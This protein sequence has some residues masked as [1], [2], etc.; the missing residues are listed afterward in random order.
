MEQRVA[1]PIAAFARHLQERLALLP[2]QAGEKASLNPSLVIHLAAHL[3]RHGPPRT[4][5]IPSAYTPP[6]FPPHGPDGQKARP[7]ARYTG[8][9]LPTADATSAGR[10][11]P[12]KILF[13]SVPGLGHVNPMLPLATALRDDL[14][15]DVRWAVCTEHCAYLAAQGFAVYPCGLGE[16]RW[17]RLE[18]L[19]GGRLQVGAA[20]PEFFGNL[21]GTVLTPPMLRDLTAV[22]EVWMPDLYVHDRNELAAAIVATAGGRIHVTSNF[23]AHPPEARIAAAARN[24]EHLWSN[25]GLEMPRLAGVYDHGFIDIYPGSLQAKEHLPCPRLM[26][27][28]AERSA[29]APPDG[30]STGENRPDLYL[31]LGTIFNDREVIQR[32]LD[33]VSELEVNVVATTGHDLGDLRVGGNTRLFAYLPQSSVL[34]LVSAVLSHA[35]SGTFLGALAHGLP[36]VCIPQGADQFMNARLGAQAGVATTLEPTEAAIHAVRS[37]V[38]SV[39]E[40]GGMRRR[41]G[42]VAGEIAAMP[43]AVEVA[44]EVAAL[45]G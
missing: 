12:L 8:D 35:G 6:S 27:R 1:A 44:A 45:V 34:P 7:V 31:T 15:H 2:G 29:G 21:F 38:S 19:T 42:E 9:W 28:P 17:R 18:E 11:G 37:A 13:S 41:A 10:A 40:D 4:A 20:T 32:A 22:A 30:W 24:V 33:A 14:G 16:E 3:C 36:Q 5:A 43:G 26:L 39:I 23:G 25:L